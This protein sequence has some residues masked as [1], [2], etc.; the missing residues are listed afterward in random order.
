MPQPGTCRLRG[1]R[2]GGALT[3]IDVRS[4]ARSERFG[5]LLALI[6]VCA[7]VLAPAGAATPNPTSVTIA[8]SLQSEVGCPGDWDPACAASHLTYDANDDVWQ[9]TFAVLA[10]S[11]E[12]KAALN[13]SWD[14]NYGLGAVRQ[15]REHP[16]LA[17]RR[18]ERE[19]L[20]RPQEPLGDRQRR[21]HHRRRAGQLPVRARLLAATGIPRAC[22]PGSRT[23]TATA[24]T[25][26][27]PASSRPAT[28]RPRPRS[29][30]AG[31]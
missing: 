25:P 17:R 1:S 21:L 20:L 14:E 19:V 26:S 18:E 5:R 30:R 7:A 12:Y 27:P 16:S 29:T 13:D 28:T 6:A 10:G 22:A 3:L 11:W 4:K 2:E 15:R 23:S 9:G 8:G 31:T 24:R